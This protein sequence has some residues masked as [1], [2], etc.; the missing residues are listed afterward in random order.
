M[1]KTTFFEHDAF[2]IIR[3]IVIDGKVWYVSSDICHAIGINNNRQALI[4]HVEPGDIKRNV[5]VQQ[6]TIAGQYSMV[7]AISEDGVT[8]LLVGIRMTNP[9]CKAFKRWL[10][11]EVFPAMRKQ[12]SEL[13][14]AYPGTVCMMAAQI[15]DEQEK[16]RRLRTMVTA[17]RLQLTCE[18]KRRLKYAKS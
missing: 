14:P 4:Q 3:A 11:A 9:L 8:S 18:R 12:C 1:T 5:Q 15:K 7:T 2:G 10:S 13:A 16:V 6:L 17:L